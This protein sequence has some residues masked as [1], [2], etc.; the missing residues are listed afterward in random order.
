MAFFFNLLTYLIALKYFLNVH[1][2]NDST[3]GEQ[4]FLFHTLLLYLCCLFFTVNLN[5]NP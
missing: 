4:A 2:T 1:V 5:E 3:T